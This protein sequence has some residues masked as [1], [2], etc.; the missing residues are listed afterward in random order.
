MRDPI[1]LILREQGRSMVWLARKIGYSHSHTK[2]VAIGL[3]PASAR[4]RAA[5]AVALDL[6]ESVLFFDRSENTRPAAMA[7]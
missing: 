1:W 6:P 4:F 2:G 5:C 3:Q 7:T